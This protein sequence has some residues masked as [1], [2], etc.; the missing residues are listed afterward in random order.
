MTYEKVCDNIDNIIDVCDNDLNNSYQLLNIIKN[1][2]KT[3]DI[4]VGD[5][6]PDYI[7]NNTILLPNPN[8]MNELGYALRYFENS[9][10]IL[11]LNKKICDKIPSM[12]SGFELLYYNS[13]YTYYYFDIV[14]K[15]KSKGNNYKSNEG[16]KTFDYSLLQKFI[17]SLHECVII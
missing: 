13:D 12:L 16:C 11:L 3:A 2:I 7:I 10:I 17:T 5:I 4:F 1:Y 15:I 8:A 9:N 14:D 6:T